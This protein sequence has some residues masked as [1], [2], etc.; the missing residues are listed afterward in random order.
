MIHCRTINVTA[1]KERAE[2]Q[3]EQGKQLS[4]PP[5]LVVEQLGQQWLCN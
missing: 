2:P 3:T 4:E 5:A 1:S